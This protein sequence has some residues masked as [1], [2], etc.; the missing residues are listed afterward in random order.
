MALPRL[1]LDPDRST[2]RSFGLIAWVAFALLSLLIWWREGFLFFSFSP[3][4]TVAVT[5]GL[6]GLSVAS[7]VLGLIY[8]PAVR[9]L[10]VG[11]SLVTFPIGFVVSHVV[12][13]VLFFGILTPVGLALRVLG[14]DP[15]QR[16]FE[17]QASTYWQ[18]RPKDPSVRS[19][20][21]QY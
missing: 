19:Y 20:F 14:K 11:L 21:R 4:Q 10:Y 16:R 3:A 7:G 12:L 2:L 1:N 6:L 17:P 13:A 15:M 18:A 5:R 8:P 9:P